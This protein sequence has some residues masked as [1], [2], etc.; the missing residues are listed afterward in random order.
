MLAL[1][2]IFTFIIYLR[3]SNSENISLQGI[4]DPLLPPG[5]CSFSQEYTTPTYLKF[6]ITDKFKCSFQPSRIGISDLLTFHNF[7]DLM[8]MGCRLGR[9]ETGDWLA[10]INW[11][12]QVTSHNIKPGVAPENIQF[13]FVGT[14]L[15]HRL[16]ECSDPIP[17]PRANWKQ[18]NK[19]VAIFVPSAGLIWD[20]LTRSTISISRDNKI[21][22]TLL[23]FT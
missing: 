4:S 1:E 10:M 21:Y 9:L 13:S 14:C 22:T 6:P 17:V 12:L 5:S 18:L 16:E 2:I 3:L 11:I 7:K 15:H 23:K 20:D 8:G 19:Q